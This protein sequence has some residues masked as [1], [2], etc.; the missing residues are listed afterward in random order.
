MLNVT[1]TDPSVFKMEAVGSS[2][3]LVAIN[4]TTQFMTWNH[5][6]QPILPPSLPVARRT[7]SDEGFFSELGLREFYIA[8]NTRMAVSFKLG[9]ENSHGLL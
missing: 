4:Q 6:V 5:P 1:S 3:T 7:L 9:A 8:S 2:K